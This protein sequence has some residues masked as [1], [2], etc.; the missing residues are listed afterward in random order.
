MSG[1]KPFNVES[2]DSS[3]E[4]IDDTEELQIEEALKIYQ[5]AITLHSH[6]LQ[7]YPAAEAAY[8][9]LLSL[10]IF[11]NIE[12]PIHYESDSAEE[13]DSESS[14]DLPEEQ[15]L[16]PTKIGLSGQYAASNLAQ[17]RYLAYKNYGQL[18]LDRLEIWTAQQSSTTRWMPDVQLCR[19]RI[20][21]AIE[22]TIDCYVKALGCD[23]SDSGLWRMTAKLCGMMGN[24]RLARFCLESALEKCESASL[25][26]DFVGLEGFYT[27][28]QLQVLLLSLNFPGQARV[29]KNK[30]LAAPFRD[31]ADPFQWLNVYSSIL[32]E[33]LHQNGSR[34][35]RVGSTDLHLAEAT[36]TGLLKV[37]SGALMDW[38]KGGGYTQDIQIILSAARPPQEM[39]QGTAEESYVDE[40]DPVNLLPKQSASV[41]TEELRKFSSATSSPDRTVRRRPPPLTARHSDSQLGI[42]STTEQTTAMST[43]RKS[44][45][46]ETFDESESTR[47][48]SKRL[49]TRESLVGPLK[50]GNR[51]PDACAAGLRHIDELHVVDDAFFGAV[52]VLV[53]ELGI[54]SAV[55]HWSARQWMETAY[56][57]Q[58][59]AVEPTITVFQALQNLYRGWNDEKGR[60]WLLSPRTVAASNIGINSSLQS[61]EDVLQ[62]LL[63]P[64][65]AR[66]DLQWDLSEAASRTET[67]M[68]T[69]L[70][71]AKTVQVLNERHLDLHGISLHLLISILSA[72]GPLDV[73]RGAC[74]EFLYTDCKWPPD[75]R[76]SLE[77]IV[78]LHNAYLYQRFASDCGTESF[79]RCLDHAR[80]TQTICELKANRLMMTISESDL[81]GLKDNDMD[82]DLQR[83]L[84]LARRRLLELA[85]FRR[86]DSEIVQLIL[87]HTWLTLHLLEKL[88]H[89]DHRFLLTFLHDFRR[90]CQE[91]RPGNT[92]ESRLCD[93]LPI[94]LPN[95]LLMEDLSLEA[96]DRSIRRI[97]TTEAFRRLLDIT[98]EDPILVINSSELLLEQVMLSDSRDIK[99]PV[100]SQTTPETI[101]IDAAMV[102]PLDMELANAVRIAPASAHIFLWR[103]LKEAYESISYQQKSLACSFRILEIIVSEMSSPIGPRPTPFDKESLTL[104]GLREIDHLVTE[105]YNSI[106]TVENIFGCMDLDSLRHFAKAIVE[107]LLIIFGDMWYRDLDDAGVMNKSDSERRVYRTFERAGERLVDTRIRLGIILYRLIQE[108]SGQLEGARPSMQAHCL[109]YMRTFHAVLSRRSAC[110]KLNLG[111]LKLAKKEVLG[112][113]QQGLNVDPDLAQLMWELHKMKIGGEIYLLENHDCTMLKLDRSTATHLI[114]FVLDHVRRIPERDLSKAEYQ[115]V[116]D[117]IDSQLPNWDPTSQME[118]NS[119]IISVYLSQSLKPQDLFEAFRGRLRIAAIGVDNDKSEW[120]TIASRGWLFAKGTLLL[121]KWKL[122]SRTQPDSAEL[123]TAAMLLRR[124]L[125][126]NPASWETWYRLAQVYNEQIDCSALS[127]ASFLRLHNEDAA[128]I[129]RNS[130]HAFSMALSLVMQT[131]DL[132]ASEMMSVGEMMM[133]YGYRLYGSAQPPFCARAFSMPDTDRWYCDEQGIHR[134]ARYPG[135]SQKQAWKISAM[136]FHRAQDYRP[137]N[138]QQHYML[139]KCNWKLSTQWL[140][141]AA[142]TFARAEASHREARTISDAERVHQLLNTYQ[143]QKHLGEDKSKRSDRC[144]ALAVSNAQEA[145]RLIPEIDKR[146]RADPILEPHYKLVSLIQKLVDPKTRPSSQVTTT[147]AR[148]RWYQNFESGYQTLRTSSIL[149]A[150]E[151]TQPRTPDDWAEFVRRCLKAL[152]RADKAGWH[153]RMIYRSSAN[154]FQQGSATV[155]SEVAQQ[156]FRRD[157]SMLQAKTELVPSLFK[158]SGDWHVWRPEYERAGRHFAYTA[159]YVD[160]YSQILESI[161]DLSSFEILLRKLNKKSNDVFEHHLAWR[162]VVVRYVATVE[163][164]TA[165]NDDELLGQDQTLEQKVFDTMY[166]DYFHKIARLLESDID[167]LCLSR[168]LVEL[169]EVKRL[170]SNVKLV[171]VPEIDTLLANIY[172]K[173]FN[174]RHL[175][176]LRES[177]ASRKF[178][179]L[180][181]KPHWPHSSSDSMP[182][183]DVGRASA[184]LHFPPTFSPKQRPASNPMDLSSILSSNPALSPDSSPNRMI[185]NPPPSSSRQP[186]S[187]TLIGHQHS[188]QIDPQHQDHPLI[189]SSP[190]LSLRFTAKVQQKGETVSPVKSRNSRVTH[191]EILRRVEALALI[192]KR[193]LGN[194]RDVRRMTESTQ[195][196]LHRIDINDVDQPMTVSVPGYDWDAKAVGEAAE[197]QSTSP[198]EPESED[199][200]STSSA[201][202][203]A[204]VIADSS[205]LLIGE[206]EPRP[207]RPYSMQEDRRVE[208]ERWNSEKADS[209]SDTSASI[210]NTEEAMI[211]GP[212]QSDA[213]DDDRSTNSQW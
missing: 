103:R 34:E 137:A 190:D 12:R 32:S 5:S 150:I 73:S 25:D 29:T 121:R 140:D 192:A 69:Q 82:A 71:L 47:G 4:E 28:S 48:R 147:S 50:S 87:R 128:S 22:R 129:E 127:D 95:C 31:N 35:A 77:V 64:S 185:S 76:S 16:A 97:Q 102:S 18:I 191:R 7:S 106:D 43:K 72:R 188:G 10:D 207:Q 113:H 62:A 182:R 157:N 96:I 8:L 23:E 115:N 122:A 85:A 136:L 206:L 167:S 83:W 110:G 61:T 159:Q 175:Q 123:H 117:K 54:N 6:G 198:R 149:T 56:E 165:I 36:W 9:E 80:G 161:R 91:S 163:R 200:S 193:L 100:I 126:W 65:T 68:N 42:I 189:A 58:P 105:I 51:L 204:M 55:D 70:N 211:V 67:A 57:Q 104:A 63:Q 74:P 186:P 139:A 44:P 194:D 120:G 146:H 197:V 174:C 202:D 14:T 101:T 135:L 169:V 107:V 179:A 59:E 78:E 17:L 125:E 130:I 124:D 15:D 20:V 3:D 30:L 148:E 144:L 27:K 199:D 98:D 92:T 180:E 37:V 45:L 178:K 173:M 13:S 86:N 160:L 114:D 212:S 116:F 187:R 111:F 60:L 153:H 168:Y 132:S 112:W 143:R 24:T 208:A 209:M 162:R 49:K 19:E 151:V 183:S 170:S 166:T 164:V 201:G 133:E 109:D 210:S 156:E 131:P 154:W 195:A 40:A 41:S 118:Q 119:A 176:Y 213:D 205:G 33:F 38:T 75:F 79:A 181:A 171:Q 66:S 90:Q 152:I 52:N 203:K 94:R 84:M 53:N 46:D 158:A 81:S 11:Q 138:W 108:T 177:E 99:S 142:K 89:V 39:M 184:Q 21:P 196:Q 145:I 93:A 2:D 141:D 26:A 155:K 88:G 134:K 172:A 1:F